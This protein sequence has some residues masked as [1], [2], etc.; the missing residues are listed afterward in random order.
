MIGPEPESTAAWVI[1]DRDAVPM[2]WADRAQDVAL[3]PLLPEE[4]T[5][6]LNGNPVSKMGRM[7]EQLLRL[8]GEG[9]SS[10]AMATKLRISERTVDR[11]VAR[12]KDRLG[13]SSRIDLARIAALLPPA[14]NGGMDEKRSRVGGEGEEA[15]S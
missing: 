14:V 3:I 15:S 4:S 11:R 12:L 8:I 7:D 2:L 6:L 5:D 1:V 10:R 9:L 13:V